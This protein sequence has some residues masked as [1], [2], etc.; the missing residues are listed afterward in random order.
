VSP[1][2]PLGLP[3]YH[4]R[5]GQPGDQRRRRGGSRSATGT[6]LAAMHS[7]LDRQ[8]LPVSLPATSGSAT[9]RRAGSAC[10]VTRFGSSSRTERSIAVGEVTP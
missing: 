1:G 7:T 8:H 10:R 4:F 2:R 3:P 5:E 9:S 6:P